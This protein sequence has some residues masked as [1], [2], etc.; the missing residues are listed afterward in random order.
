MNFV[1]YISIIFLTFIILILTWRLLEAYDFKHRKVVGAIVFATAFIFTLFVTTIIVF[2]CQQ[3]GEIPI[4]NIV[5]NHDYCHS[6]GAYLNI[7]SI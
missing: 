5:T 2:T 4:K 1:L 6:C 3:C 7:P